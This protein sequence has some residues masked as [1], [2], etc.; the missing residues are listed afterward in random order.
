MYEPFDTPPVQDPSFVSILKIREQQLHGQ[1]LHKSWWRVVVFVLLALILGLTAFSSAALVSAFTTAKKAEALIPNIRQAFE[2]KNLDEA[3]R[4]L[5]EAGDDIHFAKKQYSYARFFSYLPLIRTQ[6]SAGS[7]VIETADSLVGHGVTLFDVAEPVLATFLDTSY[8]N[9]TGEQKETLLKE[10]PTLKDELRALKADATEGQK[11]LSGT[12]RAGT[13]RQ[14]SV[15]TTQLT[16]ALPEIEKGVSIAETWADLAPSF[17][18]ADT[19]RRYLVL[20]LNNRELRPGGGFIGSYGMMTIQNGDIES[21]PI[22]D[23]YDLDRT[24]PQG[25]KPPRPIADYLS[26]KWFMRDS[27]WSPDF[28]ASAAQT[29]ALYRTES[30]DTERVDGVIALT[31]RV[32]EALLQHTG[33]ISVPGYPYTFTPENFTETLQDAV[34]YDFL[35]LG[36]DDVDRKQILTGLHEELLTR[37]LHLESSEIANFAREFLTLVDE[38]QFFVTLSKNFPRS[39]DRNQALESIGWNGAMPK[40]S[41]DFLMLVD[42]NFYALKSD[43][44]VHRSIQYDVH[45]TNKGNL[46]AHVSVTYQHGGKVDNFTDRYQ[47]YTRLFVPKGSKLLSSKNL[48]SDVT[49][50]QEEGKT[51]FGFLKR[52]DPQTS[53]TIE[54][55]YTLPDSLADMVKEG[56][57]T[58]TVPKQLGGYDHDLTVTFQGSRDILE[59]KPYNHISQKRGERGQ[60]ITTNLRFDRNFTITFK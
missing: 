36:I 10:L 34:E 13:L 5:H 3:A 53:Q 43:P 59:V 4:L 38:K 46:E 58:L 44:V 11:A 41:G 27:N 20:F 37:I 56:S 2:E 28:P 33:N 24:F 25:E 42:A 16:A 1:T 23:I 49:T 50:T 19:P 29:L 47:T 54:L 7:A 15:L 14:I 8:G 57:Y 39:S 31:P 60:V 22:S 30:G 32:I 51:A 55:T 26:P 45:A 52:I 6:Y 40:T 48:D 18:G 12:A 21:F 17:L 9:L 35:N